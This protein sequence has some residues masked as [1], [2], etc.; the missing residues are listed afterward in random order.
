MAEKIK[1]A[2]KN[3]IQAVIDETKKL[4]RP[5]V[6]VGSV[7]PLDENIKLFVDE[8]KQGSSPQDYYTKDEIDKK[9]DSINTLI[10]NIGSGLKLKAKGIIPDPADFP[11]GNGGYL[12]QSVNF[13]TQEWNGFYLIISHT[14]MNP[15]ATV[16]Y[17]NIKNSYI[18]EVKLISSNGNNFGEVK[19]SD[20]VNFE[21]INGTVGCGDVIYNIWEF[22][23]QTVN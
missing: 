17:V 18:V 11:D 8:N 12:A 13:S 16:Y 23:W 21:I 6:A 5:E 14:E 22:P 19:Q 2:G 10:S 4:A 9:I 15:V 1:V 7:K 3:T 20:S